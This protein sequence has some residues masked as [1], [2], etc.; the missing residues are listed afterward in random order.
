MTTALN[1][2]QQARN[3][4]ILQDL[5]ATVPGNNQCADC[6]TKNP[7]MVI[8]NETERGKVETN[9]NLYSMGQLERMVALLCG[10]WEGLLEY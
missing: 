8:M 4:R 2:R 7:G 3:E 9:V 6:G 5:I 10:G 1:K